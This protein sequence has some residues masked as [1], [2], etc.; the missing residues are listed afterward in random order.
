MTNSIFDRS[1]CFTF[2]GNWLE[3]LEAMENEH[4]ADDTAYQMFKTIARYSL[5]GEEPVPETNSVLGIM[6]PIL[7]RE[8]DS[9]VSNRRRGFLDP[10]PTEKQKE[11]I[12]RYVD[13]PWMSQR[14]IADELGVS[15]TTVNSTIQKFKN[16]PAPFGYGVHAVADGKGNTAVEYYPLDA[17]EDT[18]CVSGG[19]SAG[20]SIS[21]GGD[22][23]HNAGDSVNDATGT[24]TVVQPTLGEG[25]FF[26]ENGDYMPF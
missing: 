14:D 13:S 8:I 23:N 24:G 2:F 6:W 9:S 16:D 15:K 17:C 18:P 11:I 20:A 10:E 26:N 3:S 25:G 7:R 19:D 12:A 21:Y 5:F 22:D 1:I 4:S